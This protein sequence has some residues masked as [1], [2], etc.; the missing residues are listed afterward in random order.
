MPTDITR[1]GAVGGHWPHGSP[2]VQSPWWESDDSG[3]ALILKVAG[4]LRASMRMWAARRP[5]ARIRLSPM[6][7]EW[8]QVHEV[9]WDKHHADM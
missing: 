3:R 1:D 4:G 2:S 9:N 8:L 7:S 5:R 6:S